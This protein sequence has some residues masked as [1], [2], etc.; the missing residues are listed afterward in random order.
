[1]SKAKADFGHRFFVFG[2]ALY[3]KALN[4]Y[5]GM[6]GKGVFFKVEEGFLQKALTEQLQIIDQWLVDFLSRKLAATRDLSPIPVLGYPGW[7][8][9]NTVEDFYDNR[10]YFRPKAGK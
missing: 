5:I 8:D 6:T 7:T 4:P 1:M 3:E 10:Q 2:H 9:E